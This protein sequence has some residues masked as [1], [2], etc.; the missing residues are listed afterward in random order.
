MASGLLTSPNAVC[1]LTQARDL[2]VPLS[3]CFTSS[4]LPPPLYISRLFSLSS[5]HTHHR[6]K[7]QA[8]KTAAA[9]KNTSNLFVR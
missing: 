4:V 3:V 1:S 6:P 5:P 7:S 8:R 9:V 2:A